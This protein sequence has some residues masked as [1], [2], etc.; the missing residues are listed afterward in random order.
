MGADWRVAEGDWGRLNLIGDLNVVSD[1]YTFPYQLEQTD[2]FAQVAGNSRSQGRVI[3]NLRA[4]VSEVS[5]G[6]VD[7]SISAWVR[8]LT[9][10]DNASNF[11]DFGPA[12]GG[13]L[14]GYFPEPRTYGLTVGVEF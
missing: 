6:G 14:L 12:F 4:T 2:P 3:A 5:L 1:Y 9:Q 10:E 11:I 8:N 7:A 13:L